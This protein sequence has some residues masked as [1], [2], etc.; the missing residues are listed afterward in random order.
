[1]YIG[2]SNEKEREKLVQKIF[3]VILDENFP[4]LMTD[5]KPQL[6]DSENTKP[7][8]CRKIKQKKQK[9]T[10]RHITFNVQKILKG[11]W[12]WEQGKDILLRGTYISAFSSKIIPARRKWNKIKCWR[13]NKHEP[14]ILNSVKLFLKSEGKIKTFSKK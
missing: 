3:E 9:P 14:R 10:T 6:L 13:K 2:V 12:W 4:K 7:D 1:M 8:K 11:V 5:S